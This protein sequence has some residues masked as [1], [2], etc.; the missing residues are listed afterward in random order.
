MPLLSLSPDAPVK[1]NHDGDWHIK[2]S[3]SR[4]ECDVVVGLDKLDVAFIV[5]YGSVTLNVWPGVYP[6]RPEQE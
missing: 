6:R 4:A 1:K 2:G 3:N 5:G